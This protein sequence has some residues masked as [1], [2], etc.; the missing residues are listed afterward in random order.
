MKKRGIVI[1]N[2]PELLRVKLLTSS[3]STSS[4]R[5]KPLEITDHPFGRL[6]YIARTQVLAETTNL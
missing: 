1:S 6:V 4:F 5:K 2:D 3:A